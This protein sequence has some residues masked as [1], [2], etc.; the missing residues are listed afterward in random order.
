MGHGKQKLSGARPPSTKATPLGLVI[1]LAAAGGAVLG[2]AGTFYLAKPKSA[3]TQTVFPFAN[4]MAQGQTVPAAAPPQPRQYTPAPQPPGEV[5]AGKV[6]SVEHGHWH[7][8]PP[9]VQTTTLPV[10]ATVETPPTP[11]LASPAPAPT[12]PPAPVAAPA[13][14]KE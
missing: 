5:P 6:W 1:A 12:P 9:I 2:S 3:P 14:K 8:L 10:T 7:D 4:T 13:E 11:L